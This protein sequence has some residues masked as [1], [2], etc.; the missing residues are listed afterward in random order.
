MAKILESLANNLTAIRKARR[1]S[2]DELA[3]KAGVKRQTISG[4][5]NASGHLNEKSPN[6]YAAYE[7]G[8]REPS[9]SKLVQLLAIVSKQD[10]LD[11][12]FLAPISAV[13]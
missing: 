2:Q 12:G 4:Y 9:V 7:R 1:L 6:G 11:L 13:S 8:E 5:E 3:T 10:H